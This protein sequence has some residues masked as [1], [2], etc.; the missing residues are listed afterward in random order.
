MKYGSEFIT[1]YNFIDT[2][3]FGMLKVE[4]I[5]S[6]NISF[7]ESEDNNNYCWYN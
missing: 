3:K 6:E 5:L 7:R 2:G 1:Q 4:K